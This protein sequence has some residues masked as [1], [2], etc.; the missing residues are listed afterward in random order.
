MTEIAAEEV[1]Y[2]V[3]GNIGSDAGY[4]VFSNGHWQHVGG[5][6]V[7]SILEVH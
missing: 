3:L 2:L 4:W 7:E 6:G 1:R 5:W